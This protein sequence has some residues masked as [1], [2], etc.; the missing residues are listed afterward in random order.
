MRK[1]Q[2]CHEMADTVR[3][4]VQVGP[5]QI[6]IQEFPRPQIGPTM[7][8]SGWRPTA[9]AAATWR[10]TRA[11]WAAPDPFIPGHDRWGSSRSRRAGRAALGRRAGRPGRAGGH[12][13]LP[14]LPA[15]LTGRY[16][17][18]RNRTIGHGVTPLKVAPGLWGG[19]RSTSTCR[20]AILHPIDKTL[21]AELAVMFNPIGA[22][23]RWAC[24]RGVGL[25]DTVLVLGA[26]QRGLAAVI[27]A[28]AAG[29]GTIIVTGL[30]P[31]RTSWRWPASSAPTTRSSW[32]TGGT[33][34]G[35]LTVSGSPSSPT[36][37]SPTSRWSSPHGHRAG[38]RRAARD[39]ARWAGGAG[40]AQG[41]H[42]G[43]AAHRSDQPGAHRGRRVRGRRPRLR[44]GHP[45]HRV[46]PVPLEKLHTHTFGLDD[47]AL[48]METLAG[49][50]VGE[51]AV[52]VS[53]HPGAF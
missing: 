10:R 16:Q 36:A 8:C 51:A 3:A 40:R 22:G 24:H 47:T 2:A 41:R 1:A 35:E 13:A 4:A 12:R 50:V 19:R 43:A 25:G 7:P 45:D 6:E 53:V 39:P 44:R 37:S 38:D 42:G 31:T 18:C 33:P 11:T 48:A 30:A 23:V 49:E 21:P 29:A 52:H 14:V 26:G 9:S 27:A 34:G 20:R 15:C 5:R 17:S 46:A 32:T 28:R